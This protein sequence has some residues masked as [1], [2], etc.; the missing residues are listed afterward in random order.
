MARDRVLWRQDP[1]RADKPVTTKLEKMPARCRTGAARSIR[2]KPDIRRF[3]ATPCI[4]A[5]RGCTGCAGRRPIL[6]RGVDAPLDLRLMQSPG[7]RDEPGSIRRP[8]R[9]CTF[10]GGLADSLNEDIGA[11]GPRARP[12]PGPETG[13]PA[14][15]AAERQ[16]RQRT[17]GV[18]GGVAGK[19]A[20]AQLA[21]I[22]TATPCRRRRAA[23]TR[24]GFRGALLKRPARL[25]RASRQSSA[26]LRRSQ[27]EDVLGQMVAAKLSVFIRE[28]QFQ[29][30]TKEKLTTPR[31]GAAD[32]DGFARPFRPFPRRRHPTQADN[33]LAFSIDRAEERLRRKRR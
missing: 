8:R 16:I 9:C 11:T 28:P 30:Q 32:R 25:G 2:F 12:K 26:C 10:P 13:R 14:R 3:S 31:G 33:L 5:R 22:P 24:P 15:I 18:G 19:T 4:L 17:A 23:R 29:G 1:M 27:A 21:C 6:F 20:E 7:A